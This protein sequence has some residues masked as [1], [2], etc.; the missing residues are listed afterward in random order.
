MFLLLGVFFL[1]HLLELVYFLASLR[2]SLLC[3]IGFLSAFLS[4]V[5]IRFSRSVFL[6]PMAKSSIVHCEHAPMLLAKVAMFLGTSFLWDSG[7]IVSTRSPRTLLLAVQSFLVARSIGFLESF[8]ATYVLDCF[9]R[10]KEGMHAPRS[11]TFFVKVVLILPHVRAR[12]C[13]PDQPR[14]RA[15]S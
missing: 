10:Q 3:G 15:R 1:D 8:L 9:E 5:E 4:G 6:K 7:S 2:K 13:L 11:T 12:L 14:R